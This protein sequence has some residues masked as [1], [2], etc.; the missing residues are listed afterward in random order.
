MPIF[1]AFNFTVVRGRFSAAEARIA[2]APDN[3]R[4]FK[5]SSSSSVQTLYLTGFIALLSKK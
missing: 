1:L 3:I 5:R 4:A 2:E